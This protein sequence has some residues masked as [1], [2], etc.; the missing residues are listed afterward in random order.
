MF[1]SPQTEVLKHE[2]VHLSTAITLGP[3][4]LFSSFGCVKIST[5][6][7]VALGVLLVCQVWQNCNVSV[8]LFGLKFLSLSLCLIDK[9][10]YDLANVYHVPNI[11]HILSLIL[12]KP[13]QDII[14]PKLL[15]TEFGFGEDG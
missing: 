6:S 14:I 7:C 13:I 5:K 8:L 11:L 1:C 2:V 4:T 15:M 10:G 9:I 3:K 12:I